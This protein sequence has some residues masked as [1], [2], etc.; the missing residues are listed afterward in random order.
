MDTYLPVPFRL[1]Q[2]NF[3]TWIFIDV[4]FCAILARYKESRYLNHSVYA[5]LPHPGSAWGALTPR[6]LWSIPPVLP[7]PDPPPIF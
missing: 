2:R 5:H 7:W 1:G 3:G 4:L 6:S